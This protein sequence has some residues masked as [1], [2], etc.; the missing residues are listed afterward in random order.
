MHTRWL[1]AT[2]VTQIKQLIAPGV[3][4][5]PAKR[6]R[7]TLTSQTLVMLAEPPDANEAGAFEAPAVTQFPDGTEHE[8]M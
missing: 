8:L 1:D 5:I 7:K 3:Q 4:H 2:Q 6:Q